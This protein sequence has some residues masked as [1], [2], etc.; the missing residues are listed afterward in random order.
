MKKTY[1]SA[2]KNDLNTKVQQALSKAGMDNKII[3][4]TASIV[5][6]KCNEEGAKKTI[7]NEIIKQYG[8]KKGLDI[9][10]HIKDILK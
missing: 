1:S 5:S 8:Q 3:S 2:E 7:Y 9:Y 4:G 6:K 10:N